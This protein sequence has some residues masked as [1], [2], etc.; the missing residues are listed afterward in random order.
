MT[1]VLHPY[2]L[3]FSPIHLPMSQVPQL[4]RT[5]TLSPLIESAGS[6]EESAVGADVCRLRPRK[7][8]LLGRPPGTRACRTPTDFPWRKHDT[9]ES[10]EAD[11]FDEEESGAEAEIVWTRIRMPAQNRAT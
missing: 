8:N 10:I 6:A 9:V 11:H 7:L 5:H 4:K 3:H 1:A 2:K